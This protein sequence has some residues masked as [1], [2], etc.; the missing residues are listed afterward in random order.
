MLLE[1]KNSS[2]MLDYGIKLMGQDIA[3][4]LSP[5]PVHGF[6][7]A[8]LLSHAHLDHSGCI[9]NLF[10]AAEPAIHCTTP[11]VPLIQILLEDSMKIAKYNKYNTFSSPMYKRMLRNTFTHNYDKHFVITSDM[12]AEFHD[13]GHILGAG[14]V[15]VHQDEYDVVYS[16][17]FN[18]T[19]TN[20]HN[21]CQP[22]GKADV[23]IVEATYGDRDHPPRKEVEEAFIAG[24]EEVT[25][26]GGSVLCPAFAVGRSQELVTLL[27]K[28]KVNVPV[29]LDGMCRKVAE[30]YLEFPEYFRDFNEMYSALT[31]VEW[32]KS[33][34]ERKTVFNEPSVIISSAGMLTG[35]PSVSY[36][37]EL[38]HVENSAVFFT[39]YQVEGTPGNQLLTST[40]FTFEELTIDYSDK[41]V[42]YFDLSAHADANG[43]HA[44]IKS[45]DPSL[46]LVNHGDPPACDAL[47]EWVNDEMGCDAFSPSLR[48]K[49]KVEDYVR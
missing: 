39:G 17:D 44:F 9:P 46:V 6:L 23:L 12:S 31:W 27:H 18:T 42:R 4:P 2:V 40:K 10:R 37:A 11:T 7:D 34:Q 21:G 24:I 5:L 35:G 41:D 45:V 36:L 48:D 29:Y 49:Y 43:L 25:D 28:N 13:A 30:V 33:T 8:V 14:N 32:I 22:P 3:Q 1:S 15:L 26:K 19:S 47:K 16:G 38:K 20:L